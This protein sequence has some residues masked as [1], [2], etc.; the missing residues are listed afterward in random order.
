MKEVERIENLFTQI[1]CSLSR[2]EINIQV[3]M[4]MIGGGVLLLFIQNLI[5]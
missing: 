3:L 1:E 2:I 5:S 4:W